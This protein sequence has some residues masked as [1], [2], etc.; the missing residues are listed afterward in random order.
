MSHDGA[1]DFTFTAPGPPG[2]RV[3]K[4]LC[5]GFSPF[6][7]VR[8]KFWIACERAPFASSHCGQSPFTWLLHLSKCWGRT[9]DGFG[10]SSCDMICVPLASATNGVR[11]HEIPVRL[12]PANHMVREAVSLR[13]LG[14][15]EVRD[16]GLLQEHFRHSESLT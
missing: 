10:F 13:R 5:P 2:C 16:G 3:C 9:V 8:Q 7:L 1:E 4:S 14:R 15:L 12:G 6:R 11:N